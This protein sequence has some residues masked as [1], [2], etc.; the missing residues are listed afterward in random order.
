MSCDN[1]AMWIP[2]YA[3]WLGLV[4]MSCDNVAILHCGYPYAL[5]LVVNEL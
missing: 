1:V 3:G 4:V 2:A 5:G